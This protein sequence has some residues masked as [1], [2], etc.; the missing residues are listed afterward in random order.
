[1]GLSLSPSETSSVVSG[2]KYDAA[3]KKN[4]FKQIVLAVHECWMVRP[5]IPG[6]K[7]SIG[8]HE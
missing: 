2:S 6:K 4:K 7:N 8:V 3:N 5:Q 1:M